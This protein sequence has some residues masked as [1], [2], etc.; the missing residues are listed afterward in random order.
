[1][2][3]FIVATDADLNLRDQ[4]TWKTIFMTNLCTWTAIHKHITQNA[5]IQPVLLRPLNESFDDPS[6]IA[7]FMKFYV[8]SPTWGNIDNRWTEDIHSFPLLYPICISLASVVRER[9]DERKPLTRE[10]CIN[11]MALLQLNI[12]N[13]IR[14][15]LYGFGVARYPIKVV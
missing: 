5:Y 13:P 10:Y 15:C 1:M 8:R 14:T 11:V 4:R 7:I 12:P 3:W 2:D 9:L 6:W